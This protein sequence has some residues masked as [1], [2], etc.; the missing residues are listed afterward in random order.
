MSFKMLLWKLNGL[1][2]TEGH[3]LVS[4][5]RAHKPQLFRAFGAFLEAN[6]GCGGEVPLALYLF[7]GLSPSSSE[8]Q[9]HLSYFLIP[10]RCAQDEVSAHTIWCFIL[11]LLPIVS[12][13]TPEYSDFK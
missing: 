6:A 8:S 7:T 13:I 10:D 11:H 9:H 2:G 1:P 4:A 12:E 3:G 5:E